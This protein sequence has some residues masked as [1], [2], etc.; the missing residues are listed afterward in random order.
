M[1]IRLLRD[2]RIPPVLSG[3]FARHNPCLTE[4]RK[5]SEAI[6]STLR[7]EPE[8][9]RTARQLKG[10]SLVATDGDVGSVQD[11]YFDDTT[12]TIRY[13]VVDAGTWLSGR[14]VLIS[15]RSVAST[16]DPHS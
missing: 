4:R 16:T 14:R 3:P 8:M 10:A 1:R 12:W 11:L 6:R 7:V 2:S 5:R 15:P 13:L 9:L